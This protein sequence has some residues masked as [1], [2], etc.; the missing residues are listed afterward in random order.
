MKDARLDKKTL[1]ALYE[2]GYRN[3]VWFCEWFLARWFKTPMK[4][5]QRAILAILLRRVDFLE[6]DPDLDRIMLNFVQYA[7]DDTYREKPIPIFWKDASGKLN[8]TVGIQVL[9]LIPRGFAK[10]TIANAASVFNIC[11]ENTKFSFYT[12]KTGKHAEKQLSS[13]AKQLTSNSRITSVFGNLKP[14]QR[15][16]EGNWSESKGIIHTTNDCILAAVGSGGQSRGMLDD[17]LRPDKLIIDD[18]EDKESVKT[19]ERRESTLDWVLSDLLPIMDELNPDRTIT[20]LANY[21]HSDCTAVN[22]SLDPEWT[23]VVLGAVGRDG[24]PLWPELWT[25]EKLEKKKTSYALQG[26]LHIF[27][28]EYFNEIRSP[29]DSKF[30]RE[31]IVVRPTGLDEYPVRSLV[32]D[33][34]FSDR[35]SADFC[36][37]CVLGMK[38]GGG[39]HVYESISKKGMSPREIVEMYLEL[40]V[41]YTPVTAGIDSQS[42]QVVMRHMIIEEMFRRK[43]LDLIHEPVKIVQ[44]P[45]D[46]KIVRVEGA[47]SVRYAL[48]VITHQK[49]FPELETQ[50]L[51]WPNGKKDAPDAEAMAITLLDEYSG[52]VG[53][54]DSSV[55]DQYPPLKEVYKGDWRTHK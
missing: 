46:N 27:Y 33:P 19:K 43:N 24:K 18:I 21:V 39:W 17:G 50:L 7:A 2:K 40:Y 25:E 29:E 10:T 5:Y 9:L 15:V 4:F 13:V 26:R 12:S 6:D 31:N 41:M 3:P 44:G 34:A 48:G 1:R 51:D 53:G 36:S 49:H 45:E 16:G 28:M 14:T 52:F 42:A 32:C 35:K 8:L 30:K 38:H 22:L 47:L 37:F 55:K 20:M 11:Y 23:T 54:G